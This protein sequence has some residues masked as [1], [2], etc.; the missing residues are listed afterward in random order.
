MVRIGWNRLSS[1]VDTTGIFYQIF[2]PK[3][4]LGRKPALSTLPLDRKFNFLKEE[5]KKRTKCGEE[6]LKLLN[7]KL[8][9]FKS[10]YRSR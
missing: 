1:S 5:I 7:K 8:S 4:N 6:Y 10:E 9:Y 2:L 3:S